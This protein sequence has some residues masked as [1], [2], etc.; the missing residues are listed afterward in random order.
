MDNQNSFN[1]DKSYKL[2]NNNDDNDCKNSNQMTELDVTKHGNENHNTNNNKK[3]CDSK[4]N[5][6][7]LDYSQETSFHGPKQICEPQ[8]FLLRR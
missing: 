1:G 2:C 7:L 3:C 5:K 8:P 4:W 6:L